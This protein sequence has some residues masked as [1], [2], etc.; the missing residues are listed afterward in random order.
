MRNILEKTGIAI[1]TVFKGIL[2]AVLWL[3]K[4]VLGAA[5]MFLLLLAFIARIFLSFFGGSK[6]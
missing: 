2:Q 1:L 5:K 3:F 6:I 4:L